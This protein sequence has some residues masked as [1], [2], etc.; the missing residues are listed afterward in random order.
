MRHITDQSGRF[1]IYNK[2]INRDR[3]SSIHEELP[4]CRIVVTNGCLDVIHAGHVKYLSE[5]KNLGDILL[6]GIN[7]DFGVR[8]LKG[9]NRPI[10]TER[11]RAEVLASMEMVDLVYI[12]NDTCAADFLELAKPDI[13]VKGGDYTLETLNPAERE[14]LERIGSKIVFI[15]LLA[16][17]STTKIIDRMRR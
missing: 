13:Y 17:R 2:I 7:S 16:G 12:F 1:S 11:D 14:V 15:P 10:N 9:D 8:V 3:L 5:A 6:V 4:A